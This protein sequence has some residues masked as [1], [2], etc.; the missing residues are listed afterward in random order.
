MIEIKFLESP[1]Y[2][3]KSFFITKINFYFHHMT[4]KDFSQ[5]F[6]EILNPA[7]SLSNLKALCRSSRFDLDDMTF[8]LHDF[9]L[10]RNNYP[11]FSVNPSGYVWRIVKNAINKNYRGVKVNYG[12]VDEIK[13]IDEITEFDMKDI[14]QKFLDFSRDIDKLNFPSSQYKVIQLIIILCPK[15]HESF[16][17]FMDELYLEAENIGISRENVRQILFRIRNFLKGND[18][19]RDTMSFVTFDPKRAEIVDLFLNSVE[20]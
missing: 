5:L 7:A 3:Q 12:S 14:K 15:D 1:N 4:T 2:F 20:E 17:E 19:L 18:G 16:S 11:G 9:S 10:E 13:S 6:P 8:C